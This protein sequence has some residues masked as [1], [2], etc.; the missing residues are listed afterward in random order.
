MKNKIALF[1]VV[2][3]V[4]GL[5]TIPLWGNCDQTF[6]AC[7]AWCALRQLGGSAI[8]LAACKADCGADNAGCLAGEDAKSLG[9]LL[10]GAGSR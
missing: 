6:Q 3:L 9:E 4:V 2:V 8:Q 10:D 1:V 7:K 5:A